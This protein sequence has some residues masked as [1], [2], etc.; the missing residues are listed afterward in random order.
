MR[1]S[2]GARS[3][4]DGADTDRFVVPKGLGGNR[5]AT[6]DGAGTALSGAGS[7]SLS[8]STTVGTSTAAARSSAILRSAASAKRCFACALGARATTAGA[9]SS[10]SDSE[11]SSSI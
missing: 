1:V 11:T 8:S 9:D 2:T 7:T 10:P 4:I 3:W 6:V 5:R